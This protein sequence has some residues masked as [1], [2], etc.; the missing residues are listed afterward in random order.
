VTHDQAKWG[1]PADL[2]APERARHYT[3]DALMAWGAD[4]FVAEAVLIV[5]ELVTNAVRHAESR[6]W[7]EL[8][9]DS[10]LL[11]IG[12]HDAGSSEPE[13][14]EWLR[15]SS[16]GMG[17]RLVDA[18]A[19]RW[20]VE[21]DELGKTVWCLLG[22]SDLIELVPGATDGPGEALLRSRAGEPGPGLDLRAVPPAEER[23]PEGGRA[24]APS[25]AGA[26]ST[27]C[28]LHERRVRLGRSTCVRR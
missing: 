18:I 24:D 11:W 6:S 19:L 17:L 22:P 8:R 21:A 20:F 27:R 12:V 9:C 23:S 15:Y 26:R 4:H 14:V 16:G 7:L 1:F 28:L 5:S 2:S 13:L 3:A 10:V 25:S